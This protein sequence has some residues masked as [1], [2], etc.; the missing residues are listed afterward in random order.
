MAQGCSQP[1]AHSILA[2]LVR[3]EIR[4]AV[5]G[6]SLP[7]SYDEWRAHPQFIQMCKQ[8]YKQV[9]RK[10]GYTLGYRLRNGKIRAYV[11]EDH[12]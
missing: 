12:Y 11:K 5:F 1:W 2:N 4:E 10:D 8:H 7:E 3:L 9:H 6:L